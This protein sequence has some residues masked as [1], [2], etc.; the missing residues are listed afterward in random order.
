M[1][2]KQ[3]PCRVEGCEETWTWFGAQQLRSFGQPPPQRM[4][5]KCLLRFNELED[6]EI[7]C[8]NPSCTKTW[9]WKR[10]AQL[11]QLQ[12]NDRVKPPS[13]LCESCFQRER[14]MTEQAVPC[15]VAGC[16]RTWTWTVDAQRRHHAWVARQQAKEAAGNRSRALAGDGASDLPRDEVGESTSSTS[17][18]AEAAS[19]TS[20]A[21]AGATD[22]RVEA[23]G[24]AAEPSEGKKRRR[25]KRARKPRPLDGPPERMCS[26]CAE[27]AAKLKPI[28]LPCKVHGCNK[29]FE[30]DRASQL[31]AWAS[32]PPDAKTSPSVPKRMCATCREFCRV[33]PD[34]AIKCGRP[35][36][37][38]T[39]T[40]K[41][42]A[43]LQAFLAGKLEDPIKLCDDCA[44]G[45]FLAMAAER[46]KASGPAQ[47]GETMPCVVVGCKGSWVY[48]PGMSLTPAVD[49][50]YPPDRMCNDCRIE[51]GLP[52]RTAASNDPRVG[53]ESPPNS[54][55]RRGRSRTGKRG[56]AQRRAASPGAA[57]V[58][59]RRDSESSAPERADDSALESHDAQAAAARWPASEPRPQEPEPP[60]PLAA[61]EPRPLGEAPT[62]DDHDASTSP[63]GQADGKPSEVTVPAGEDATGGPDASRAERAA[64]TGVSGDVAGDEAK[65]H[66]HPE[67]ADDPIDATR[68]AE[69]APTSDRADPAGTPVEDEPGGEPRVASEETSPA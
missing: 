55:N 24:P 36:C 48:T 14:E 18:E 65:S 69:A 23:A 25:S 15:K 57:G 58:R 5:D 49:G 34:R 42:G 22:G 63:M 62:A 28:E 66:E 52:P 6:K 32:L 19:T 31:R 16:S 64:T 53:S 44:K 43:Q 1:R 12:R 45:Q 8:R 9:T 68:P 21:D 20:D 54:A 27:R 2:D 33:H 37:T 4:C 61:R 40:Y 67:V 56:G 47:G 59:N 35:D 30:W 50:E 46:A 17:G 29:T 13:R 38:T 26:V 60:E 3:M 51:R 41:T 7:P 10:G 39:W 11:H